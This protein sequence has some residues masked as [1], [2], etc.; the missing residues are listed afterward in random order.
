[1]PVTVDAGAERTSERLA[2][3]RGGNEA[4][5]G[6]IHDVLRRAAA[7]AA[8]GDAA[9]RAG[10]REKTGPRLH[11]TRRRSVPVR[12]AAAA[13]PDVRGSL[14]PRPQ[15]ARGGGGPPAPSSRP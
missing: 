10:A 13:V 5:R 12:D 15:G 8:V 11:R 6:G 7:A 9:S 14:G 3:A 2:G 4:A 1:D